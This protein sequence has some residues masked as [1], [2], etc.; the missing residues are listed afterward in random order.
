MQIIQA[1]DIQMQTTHNQ[2]RYQ[3]AR[4][5]PPVQSGTRH[6]IPDDRCPA[7]NR[8]G[9]CRGLASRYAT[10]RYEGDT[11]LLNASSSPFFCDNSV[12]ACAR[13]GLL[14]SAK[15]ARQVN[16]RIGDPALCQRAPRK[17]GTACL[18]R[19]RQ[20]WQV[21]ADSRKSRQQTV[22][23]FDADTNVSRSS[24]STRFEIGDQQ[25]RGPCFQMANHWPGCFVSTR[26][27]PFHL[28]S[29]VDGDPGSSPTPLKAVACD[30]LRPLSPPALF[31]LHLHPPGTSPPWYC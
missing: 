15:P 18:R 2:S 19:K 29:D 31:H 11:L 27:R 13:C 28:R 1:I 8:T 25:Q 14:R 4:K 6:V 22:S 9:E 5:R 10:V 30:L 24:L 21:P 7:G 20:A 17:S 16:P 3:S 12:R 23:T 26:A